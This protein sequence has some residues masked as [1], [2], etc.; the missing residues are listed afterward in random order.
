LTA[1]HSVNAVEPTMKETCRDSGMNLAWREV[2]KELPGY[3]RG[4][5]ALSL[6]CGPDPSTVAM[7]ART[8]RQS[9]SKGSFGSC[10]NVTSVWGD[11]HVRAWLIRDC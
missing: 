6:A 11:V 7:G 2:L 10:A 8:D 1:G 3:A 4:S 5:E 9:I